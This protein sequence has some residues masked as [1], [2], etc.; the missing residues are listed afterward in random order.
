M[1]LKIMLQAK[2]INEPINAE[3]GEA[4]IVTFEVKGKKK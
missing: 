4:Q 1:K 2:K 3:T